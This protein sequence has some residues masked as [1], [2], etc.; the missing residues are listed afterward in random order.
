MIPIHFFKLEDLVAELGPGA[1]VRLE[2]TVQ[3]NPSKVDGVAHE[4]AMVHVRAICEGQLLTF[5]G[6]VGA[7]Q[8]LHGTALG[9]GK[10]LARLESDL[11]R[12]ERAVAEY[13]SDHEL[14]VRPGLIDIGGAR[15]VQGSWMGI[16][17]WRENG[18]DDGNA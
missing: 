1:E 4:V 8:T 13:L 2:G 15:L 6:E 17:D 3:T 10:D 12:A 14:K 18:G 11:R 16:P 5:M 7:V 9:D